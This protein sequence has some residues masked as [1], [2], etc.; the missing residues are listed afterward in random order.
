MSV[1]E[2]FLLVAIGAAAGVYGTIIGAGGGFLL[3]PLLVV[4]FDIEPAEVVGTSLGVVLVNGFS[5]TIIHARQRRI[6]WAVGLRVAILA[7]PA[8]LA[9]AYLIAEHVSGAVFS[10]LL[11]L[12]LLG[13]ALFIAQRLVRRRSWSKA[14]RMSLSPPADGGSQVA[15]GDDLGRP[16]ALLPTR[17][18]SRRRTTELVTA[19][20]GLGFISGLFGIGAGFLLVPLLVTWLRMAPHYATA[21]SIF[22]LIPYSAAAFLLQVALDN[23][24][25]EFIAAAAPPALIGAQAGGYVSARIHP[26]R[27]MAMLAAATMALG[28]FLLVDG[29]L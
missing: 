26:S 8:S 11:G 2:G 20:G 19:G 29:S 27:V 9:A 10:I 7:I 22:A 14:S 18:L 5:G 24:V 16:E 3:A 25:W 15:E 13:L 12:L 17:S 6:E 1:E 4:L 23:V 28:I 21:T